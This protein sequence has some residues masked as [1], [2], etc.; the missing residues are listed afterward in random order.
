MFKKQLAKP[1]FSKQTY[2]LP[3]SKIRVKIKP[4]L[5]LKN[6]KIKKLIQINF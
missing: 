1:I 5:M 2:N 6:I 4:V 3:T